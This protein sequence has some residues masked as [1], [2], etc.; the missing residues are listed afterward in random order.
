MSSTPNR[1]RVITGDEYATLSAEAVKSAINDLA[2][3]AVYKFANSK[4]A[5]DG[6]RIE[7]YAY[8]GHQVREM[9]LFLL[10]YDGYL[11]GRVIVRPLK[12]SLHMWLR[13]ELAGYNETGELCA[14]Q[15]KINRWLSTYFDTV[16]YSG[17]YLM[18]GLT[19]KY[20]SLTI[21]N[22]I[23]SAGVSDE[24]ASDA[25]RVLQES[26]AEALEII[27]P[28]LEAEYRLNVAAHLTVRRDLKN[29][30]ASVD[31]QRRQ[32]EIARREREQAEAEEHLHMEKGQQRKKS[33]TGKR[34][35]KAGRRRSSGGGTETAVVKRESGE[36]GAGISK[37]NLALAV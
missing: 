30:A 22:L 36:T 9:R 23:K 19:L 8:I 16:Y 15:K 27:E 6:G 25:V 28:L 33:E 29:Y 17:D 13:G 20:S 2:G 10:E 7:W 37:L 24:K 11:R 4:E 12:E 5:K 21:K 35:L 26:A 18:C 34:L 32:D 14:L 3:R 31:K 1:E